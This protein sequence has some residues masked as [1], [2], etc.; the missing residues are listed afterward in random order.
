MS[1]FSIKQTTT[2]NIP[3]SFREDILELCSLI[4]GD[5]LDFIATLEDILDAPANETEWRNLDGSV[6]INFYKDD[7]RGA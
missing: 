6:F 4:E 5:G 7:K 3:E 2:I 1:K